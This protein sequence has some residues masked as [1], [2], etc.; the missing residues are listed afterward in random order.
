VT[1]VLIT[2][3]ELNSTDLRGTTPADYLVSLEATL[4]VSVGGVAVY[5][6]PAFPVAELARSL[7]TWLADPD[8]GDFEF[9]SMSFEEVGAVAIRRSQS[10]WLVS[11]VFAPSSS[12]SPLEWVVVRRSVLSF[13]RRVEDDLVAL[14]VDPVEVL[15]S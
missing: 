15:G 6:E 12:S 7:K 8:R 4:C 11:S 13:I 3:N 2:Y 1:W 10:G 14:G 9:E 5:E